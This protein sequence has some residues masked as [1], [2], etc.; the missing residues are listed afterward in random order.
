MALSHPFQNGE[1]AL[2]TVETVA[3]RNGPIFAKQALRIQYWVIHHVNHVAPT[4][5]HRLA[6]LAPHEHQRPTLSGD[7]SIHR[8]T[9]LSP[10]EMD[11]SPTTIPPSF[12][13]CDHETSLEIITDS[14]G[15]K[16]HPGLAAEPVCLHNATAG[17]GETHA[18][19]LYRL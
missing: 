9:A 17:R 19:I 14:L 1:N 16:P 5:H 13:K 3:E 15:P 12:E 4:D 11:H 6:L 2:S 18:Y 8:A 7:L 10:P